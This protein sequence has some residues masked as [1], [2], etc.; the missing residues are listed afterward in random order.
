MAVDNTPSSHCLSLGATYRVPAAPVADTW[1]TLDLAFDEARPRC[2][3]DLFDYIKGIGFTAP[4][5]RVAQPSPPMPVEVQP[6]LSLLPAGPGTPI[7]FRAL[8]AEARRVCFPNTALLSYVVD[9]LGN[10]FDILA[11]PAPGSSFRLANSGVNWGSADLA[12]EATAAAIADAVTRGV[13]T[14]VDAL[15]VLSPLGAVPKKD[16]RVRI[17]NDLSNQVNRSDLAV[18]DTI[19]DAGRQSTSPS[20][21]QVV[22]ALGA[23]APDEV[24]AGL[25]I[26]FKN[27]FQ[28]APVAREFRFMLGQHYNGISY[29]NN[30]LPFGLASSPLIFSS[31]AAVITFLI[32]N[33]VR[34]VI[35]YD[36]ADTQASARHFTT[37]YVDDV[38]V[39]A[40]QRLIA[41]VQTAVL[42]LLARLRVPIDPSKTQVGETITW[43]GFRWAFAELRLGVEPAKR[44]DLMERVRT[45]LEVGY[46][47]RQEALSL[48]GALQFSLLAAPPARCFLQRLYRAIHRDT[49]AERR[50]GVSQSLAIDLN[51]L[52]AVLAADQGCVPF[53]S[54][55]GLVVISDAA[56]D[57]GPP[58]RGGAG[59]F[60]LRR[61]SQDVW[62]GYFDMPE[63]ICA[64]PEVTADGDPQ[65][66]SS[67]L[68]EA[69]GV[70]VAIDALATHLALRD[71][72]IL[73]VCDNLG[74]V[75][76]LQRGRARSTA[77]NRALCTL[78]VTSRRLD[79]RLHALHLARTTALIQVADGL[80]RQDDGLLR[81]AFTSH[82]LRRLATSEGAFCLWAM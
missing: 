81:T 66:P 46:I 68:F 15:L 65:R 31:I 12:P 54:R 26:D 58:V 1:S 72:D 49:V 2:D 41:T 34:E 24:Y 36:V 82:R 20:A 59:F 8:E 47:S 60:A 57:L 67:S 64:L 10:G 23:L 61:E 70:A 27:A 38:L 73:V 5:A 75:Q 4:L 11:R 16:G 17:I 35:G 42:G 43:I 9:G 6:L 40:P 21:A 33:V 39:V 44:M 25:S 22:L 13:I 28:L 80:S 14:A 53:R 18:N 79:L 69:V 45:V 48:V 19:P 30:N 77:V 51:M 71:Q 7:D 63:D 78:L 56:L 76:A 32:D 62:Y 74:V 55:P 3:Y 37:V 50:I 52:L 29:V